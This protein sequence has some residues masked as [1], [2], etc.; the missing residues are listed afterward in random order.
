[1]F[2]TVAAASF[3]AAVVLA[4]ALARLVGSLKAEW[5]EQPLAAAMLSFLGVFVGS[6]AAS[7]GMPMLGAMLASACGAIALVRAAAWLA[8]FA[9]GDE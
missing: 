2:G 7:I 6:F 8:V 4:W 3:V 5:L 9:A 1:V